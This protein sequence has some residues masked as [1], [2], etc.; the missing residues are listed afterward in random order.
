M[1]R[2]PLPPQTPN[3]H[4]GAVPDGA[5]GG[6]HE[7]PTKTLRSRVPRPYEV[8]YAKPPAGSRFKPG[9]SGNP[10]GRPKGRRTGQAPIMERLNT[11][12]IEEAYRN[13]KVNDG[14]RRISVPI[15]QAAIRSLAVN[16]AKGQPRA[17]KQFADLVRDVEAQDRADR[18]K[19]LE[20]A[21]E[22]KMN[23]TH[24]IQ[25]AKT[26]GL[27]PPDPVPHPDDI[28][29]D[30][31]TD[32]VQIVGPLTEEDKVIHH[33]GWKAIVQLDGEIADAELR[34]ERQ[35][36]EK[37]VQKSND[38]IHMRKTLRDKLAAFYGE[39]PRRIRQSLAEPESS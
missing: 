29:V 16:A 14:E 38:Y 32:Q 19:W 34:L 26:Q 39:P 22:Y 31:V 8:G 3:P 1:P 27:T 35:R 23:W 17:Q 2:K 37:A 25:R 5:P 21:M 7:L 4:R 33:A 11:I 9:Q 15:A 24:E 30:F 12:V 6:E 20:T 28:I 36:S 13:V 10:S 18:L